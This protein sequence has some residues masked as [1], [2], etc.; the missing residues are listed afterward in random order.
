[1][2][3]LFLQYSLIPFAYLA[4]PA[5]SAGTWG[6]VAPLQRVNSQLGRVGSSSPT[7]IKP[8]PRDWGCGVLATGPPGKPHDT[9]SLVLMLFNVLA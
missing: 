3:F 9:L 4:A 8:G 2:T 6:P 1:M 7:G 5:L